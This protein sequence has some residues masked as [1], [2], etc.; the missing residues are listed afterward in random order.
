[1]GS[2][3]QFISAYVYSG[4]LFSGEWSEEKEKPLYFHA[5]FCPVHVLLWGF[6]LYGAFLSAGGGAA[7]LKGEKGYGQGVYGLYPDLLRNFLACLRDNADQ[8]YE[9]GNR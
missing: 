9:M 4:L 5:V 2:G 1:M 6:F 8:L 7:A 3:L